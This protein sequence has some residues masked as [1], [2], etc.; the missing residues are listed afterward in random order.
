[1]VVDGR[2]VH[3]RHEEWCLGH[4]AKTKGKTLVCSKWL[5]K[6]KNAL[7]EHLQVQSEV[8]VERFS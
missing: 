7:N 5:Y 1:M 8:R 4:S 6:I 3:L 2:G